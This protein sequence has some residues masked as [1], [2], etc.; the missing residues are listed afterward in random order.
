MAEGTA[1]EGI[2]PRIVMKLV[3][4]HPPA[5]AGETEDHT[6]DRQLSSALSDDIVEQYVAGL[7]QNI[8]ISVNQQ[9]ID[10]TTGASA[11]VN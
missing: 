10:T 7:R 4:V 11:A 6:L 3:E 2:P 1:G 5:K 9:L 8:D